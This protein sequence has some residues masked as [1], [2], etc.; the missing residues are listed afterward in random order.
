MLKILCNLLVLRKPV[1]C[2]NQFKGEPK[3]T[4]TFIDQKYWQECANK[5]KLLLLLLLFFEGDQED[6]LTRLGQNFCVYRQDLICIAISHLR[7]K[8]VK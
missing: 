1:R 3:K 8:V 6:S 2:Y 5:G 7:L 4:D